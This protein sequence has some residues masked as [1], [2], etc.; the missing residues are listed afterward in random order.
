MYDAIKKLCYAYCLNETNCF[1]KKLK[2][3]KKL[4]TSF[5]AMFEQIFILQQCTVL[6]VPF[7]ITFSRLDYTAK[8]PIRI[9]S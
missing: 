9:R 8:I 7:I 2:V 1:T 3:N 6:N 5:N 4:V